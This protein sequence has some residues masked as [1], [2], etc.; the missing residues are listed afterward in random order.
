MREFADQLT[1]RTTTVSVCA[2]GGGLDSHLVQRA[3]EPGAHLVVCG[4]GLQD[5]APANGS[6]RSKG[7]LVSLAHDGEFVSEV[8]D[9]PLGGIDFLLGGSDGFL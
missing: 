3:I 2:V 1:C 5:V 6:Q 7:L 4:D 8:F 9:P